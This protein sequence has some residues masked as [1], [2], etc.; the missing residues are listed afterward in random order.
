MPTVAVNSG[1]NWKDSDFPGFANKGWSIGGSVSWPIWD[2]GATQAAIKKAEAGV[3]VAQEQLLQSRE[4][5]ELEVRQD[6]LNILAAK[7]QI[8]STE[9]SVAE[10]EEAYKI[11]AVRYSSGVGTNLDVLD[12]EL[13]LSTARTNYISALYNYNIGLATL[14]NAMGI[15]AVIHPEFAAGSENK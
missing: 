11:A 3:K 2:G 14:E 1:Y 15:P 6:Y 7:E 9:A 13:Q 5:V 8:R 4:S 12:A 10:A